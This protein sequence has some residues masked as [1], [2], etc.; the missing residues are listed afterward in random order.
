VKCFLVTPE[1]TGAEWTYD[2]DYRTIA[3]AIGAELFDVVTLIPNELACYVDDEGLLKGRAVNVVASILYSEERGGQSPIVGPA[4]FFR[5][6][7]DG[8]MDELREVGLRALACARIAMQL[9]A[10][11]WASRN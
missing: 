6:T 5:P 9:A 8:D 11:D 1:G 3:P 2:G 7:P 4:L 10:E